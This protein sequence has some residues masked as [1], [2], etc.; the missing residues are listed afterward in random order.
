MRL[1]VIIAALT[2]G[3]SAHDPT[4]DTES[5]R[6]D[7]VVT[8]AYTVAVP[9]IRPRILKA[10]SASTDLRTSG[11]VAV[12]T[13]RPRILKGRAIVAP[14]VARQGCSAHDPTEDTESCERRC[15]SRCVSG[16][17]CPRSDRGY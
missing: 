4:E 7:L 10:A 15:T 8:N 9:T 12:P 14:A 3:C 1:A 17:Q 16:L 11:D 13:I 5:A 2:H 6:L